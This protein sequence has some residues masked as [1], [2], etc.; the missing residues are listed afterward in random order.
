MV[1]TGSTICLSVGNSDR[2]SD[3][4]SVSTSE[5]V[6]GSVTVTVIEKEV[7][8][9]ERVLPGVVADTDLDVAVGSG[10]DVANCREGA[11]RPVGVNNTDGTRRRVFT[12]LSVGGTGPLSGSKIVELNQLALNDLVARTGRD[13]GK[14]VGRTDADRA[15]HCEKDSRDDTVKR[16]VAVNDLVGVNVFVLGNAF[17]GVKT[18]LLLKEALRAKGDDGENGTVGGTGQP[19]SLT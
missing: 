1:G 9:T 8:V 7:R 17:E 12:R 2:A 4:V 6:C 11:S 10:S 16:D 18:K 14:T 19:L 5:S 13:A 15:M 3:S